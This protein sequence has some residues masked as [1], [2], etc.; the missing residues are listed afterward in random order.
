MN[1]NTI[2]FLFFIFFALGT[3]SIG[4]T[5]LANGHDLAGITFIIMGF[6]E[7]AL[8]GWFLHRRK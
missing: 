8:A 6:C 2:A 4:S 1:R 3:V 5:A 7:L